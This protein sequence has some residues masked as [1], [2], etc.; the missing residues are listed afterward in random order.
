MT[1]HRCPSAKSQQ[2]SGIRKRA[3]GYLRR[4]RSSRPLSRL[5]EPR[6]AHLPVMALSANRAACE[7]VF[8]PDEKQRLEVAV[9]TDVDVLPGPRAYEMQPFHGG[10][11]V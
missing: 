6:F 10:P 5:R 7:K 3:S 4:R 2:R 9:D 11:P 8:A 1:A